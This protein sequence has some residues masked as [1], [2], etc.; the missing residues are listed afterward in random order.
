M[1]PGLARTAALTPLL[2]RLEEKRK[3]LQPSTLTLRLDVFPAAH[4]PHA[5]IV[6]V[7]PDTLLRGA[8]ERSVV[9]PVVGNLRSE[10]N[11]PH[12]VRKQTTPV[13]V[14]EIYGRS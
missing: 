7:P 5:G 12:D 10:S 4:D 6:D 3:R 9:R 8:D 2:L 11:P 1:S 13:S 14:A